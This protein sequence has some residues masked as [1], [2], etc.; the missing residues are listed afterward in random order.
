MKAEKAAAAEAVATT[1]EKASTTEEVATTKKASTSEPAA[2]APRLRTL[3]RVRT[4]LLLPVLFIVADDDHVAVHRESARRVS[5]LGTAVARERGVGV[6]DETSRRR[7]SSILRSSSHPRLVSAR[8]RPSVRQPRN[9]ES[10]RVPLATPRVPLARTPRFLG[11]FRRVRVARRRGFFVWRARLSDDSAPARVAA[12]PGFVRS[13]VRVHVGTTN[14]VRSVAPVAQDVP[15]AVHAVEAVERA[16]SVRETD[17]SS[18]CVG[19]WRQPPLLVQ[20]EAPDVSRGLVDG[21]GVDDVL[22]PVHV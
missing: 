6:V 14:V 18:E 3:A 12:E 11:A 13:H 4:L 21:L 10:T 5:R 7:V 19:F 9:T 1:V 8:V 16:P 2:R 15:P 20:L 22:V 17:V